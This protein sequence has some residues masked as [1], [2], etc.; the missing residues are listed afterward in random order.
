MQEPL[1]TMKAPPRWA[2]ALF[3]A[4][5]VAAACMAFAAR[6]Q[7]RQERPPAVE[8]QEVENLI[9]ADIEL[10]DEAVNKSA[11]QL[12]DRISSKEHRYACRAIVTGDPDNCYHLASPK[13]IHECTS[14]F[15]LNLAL[16]EDNPKT[17]LKITDQAMHD[18]CIIKFA[19]A[20]RNRKLCEY[21]SDKNM[22]SACES[23]I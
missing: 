8:R 22:T 16:K 3:L 23:R 10:Y 20:A 18:S 1:I 11:V 4:L 9:K 13:V 12:C 5:L 17:C 6:S 21:L 19:V 15:Y 2:I 7:T 14:K